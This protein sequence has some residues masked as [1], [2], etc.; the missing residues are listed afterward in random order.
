MP[1]G[2]ICCGG[3]IDVTRRWWRTARP[4]SSRAAMPNVDTSSGAWRR[5]AASARESSA[6]RGAHDFSIDVGD[7]I[8]ACIDVVELDAVGD[9][10]GVAAERDC[11]LVGAV[12]DDVEDDL[13]DLRGGEVFV[14]ALLQRGVDQHGLTDDR[15]G[16]IE[17]SLLTVRARTGIVR[18]EDRCVARG[19]DRT[20]AE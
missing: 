2:P 19:I 5:S 7:D 17:R 6:R 20:K 10:G 16:Q 15:I 12:A 14:D 13:G 18:L 9:V 1:R 11:E 8:A 4:A 3:W